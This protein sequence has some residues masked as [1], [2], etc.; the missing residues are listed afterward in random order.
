MIR[1]FIVG[2]V[3]TVIIAY[4]RVEYIVSENITSML[5]AGVTLLEVGCIL[6]LITTNMI[7]RRR[8]KQDC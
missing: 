2:A 3:F 5:L 4:L 7:I 6:S 8:H 1:L